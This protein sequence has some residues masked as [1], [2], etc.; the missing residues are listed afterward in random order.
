MFHM[1]K[2]E[3]DFGISTA[4]QHSPTHMHTCLQC[5]FEAP[6]LHAMICVKLNHDA[7]GR[8][9]QR[10]TSI[11][12]GPVTVTRPRKSFLVAPE[13]CASLVLENGEVV[14]AL[15]GGSFVAKG[16]LCVAGQ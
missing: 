13:A 3:R 2:G 16:D 12:P 10:R 15:L 14:S 11:R 5:D 8:D 7:V 4:G 9:R 6:I 1:R